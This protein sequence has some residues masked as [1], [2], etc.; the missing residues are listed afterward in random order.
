[1]FAPFLVSGALL[2]VVGVVLGSGTIRDMRTQSQLQYSGTSTMATVVDYQSG[3]SR[4]N[5]KV[6]IYYVTNSG[7]QTAMLTTEVADHYAVGDHVAVVY[8][9]ANPTSVT[10]QTTSAPRLNLLWVANFL[11]IGAFLV[12][13]GAVPAWRA[14]KADKGPQQSGTAKL[15]FRQRGPRRERWLEISSPTGLRPYYTKVAMSPELPLGADVP[16]TFTGRL[17]TNETVVVST[18]A[19][20]V[21]PT[22]RLKF[23]PPPFATW[24]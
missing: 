22:S 23:E 4:T 6:R 19:G 13:Y 9:A 10:F 2:I 3:S 5:A 17:H 24:E 16:I 15:W 11:G 1:M 12:G 7:P 14:A 18:D 21:W 20:K 8:D